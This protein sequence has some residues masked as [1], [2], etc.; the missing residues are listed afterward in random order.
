[1][2]GIVKEYK[3]IKKSEEKEEGVTR[4]GLLIITENTSHIYKFKLLLE[5][6]LGG[7]SSYTCTDK[8][9]RNKYT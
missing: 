2:Q 5:L 3:Q 7:S 9:N 1:M 8:T 4:N 6:A